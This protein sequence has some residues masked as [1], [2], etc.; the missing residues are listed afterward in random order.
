MRCIEIGYDIFE[1]HPKS[2]FAFSVETN[3]LV[4]VAIAD[5]F[6]NGGF[7]PNNGNKISAMDANKNASVNGIE[8]L[9]FFPF[10]TPKSVKY[11]FQETSQSSIKKKV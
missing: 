9:I 10:I 3:L 8:L 7:F 2:V 4:P 6:A 11:C 1:V 5:F